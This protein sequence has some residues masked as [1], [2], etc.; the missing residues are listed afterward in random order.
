M[1]TALRKDPH[2]RKTLRNSSHLC[3]VDESPAS[4][5]YSNIHTYEPNTSLSISVM[6]DLLMFIHSSESVVSFQFLGICTVA[7]VL[8][9]CSQG[10]K[11]NR[12]YWPYNLLKM[13]L[14]VSIY[15]LYILERE[16]FYKKILFQSLYFKISSLPQCVT[17]C[18]FEIY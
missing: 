1:V 11:Q 10:Q 6:W 7:R 4:N 16:M 2:F 18:F 5:Q 9:T 13:L 3:Y 17:C 8:A 15:I 14:K 12:K